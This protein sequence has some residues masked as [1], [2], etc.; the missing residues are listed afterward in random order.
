MKVTRR[1][2]YFGIR[3]AIYSAIER[4][5]TSEA[6][7]RVEAITDAVAPWNGNIYWSIFSSFTNETKKN[8]R[9]S[10]RGRVRY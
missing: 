3:N 8:V 6:I 9:R 5:S 1:I 4:K 2:D 7:N 10:R